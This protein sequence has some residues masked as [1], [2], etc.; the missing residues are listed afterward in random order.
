[1]R[2]ADDGRPDDSLSTGQ[3]TGR[4]CLRGTQRLVGP[5]AE[6]V[7]ARSG[8]DPARSVVPGARNRS[9]RRGSCL[10]GK[11]MPDAGGVGAL[12]ARLLAPGANR[13]GAWSPGTPRRHEPHIGGAERRPL[14][15]SPARWYRPASEHRFGPVG[16]C[17]FDRA[18][19][20]GNAS[21]GRHWAS[22]IR[23]QKEVPGNRQST[24]ALA[25]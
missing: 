25:A 1:V 20:P 3:E 9:A 10:G 24:L 19:L 23:W 4:V 13:P 17:G 18:W 7:R 11:E 2:Y 8:R 21:R 14:A 15:V 5:A 12:D 16:M 22:L 6:V